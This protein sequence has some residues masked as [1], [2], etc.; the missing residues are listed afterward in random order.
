MQVVGPPPV[1]QQPS[2]AQHVPLLPAVTPQTAWGAAPS[3]SHLAAAQ[4]APAAQEIPH[5]PQ[6]AGSVWTSMQALPHH[7]SP[8]GQHWPEVHVSPAAHAWPQAPQFAASVERSA[9]DAVQA[10]V[11]SGHTH[12]PPTHA[13][14]ASVHALPHPPQFAGS[15]WTSV[16]TPL[17]LV[18]P[19]AHAHVPAVHT[20]CAWQTVPH[21]PQL[22]TSL[23]TSVQRGIDPGQDVRAPHAHEPAAHVAPAPH[24][25]PHPPQLCGSVWY[26]AGS[27][28][29][30][31][32]FTWPD[33]QLVV[34]VVD[35]VQLTRS[36]ETASRVE[37]RAGEGSMGPMIRR[38]R[39]AG[40]SR[41]ARP[42]R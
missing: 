26:V 31:L 15:V 5:P 19:P 33:G 6:F 32:H 20:S 25:T 8:V 10:V 34:L 11:P 14:P 27:T 3:H 21:A 18:Y 37:I 36:R 12:R 23:C 16:Q 24:A 7:A 40:G 9:H 38:P 39:G 35:V 1:V 17:H 13:S 4:L 29:N 22:W 28:Q 41:R 2:P 30:P 42:P